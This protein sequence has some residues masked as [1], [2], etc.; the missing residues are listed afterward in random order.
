[1]ENSTEA[2]QKTKNRA[3]IWPNNST[4]DIYPKQMKTL[5]Q[6]GIISY[7][8]SVYSS[9][10]YNY[11]LHTHCFYIYIHT[12]EY[13]SAFKKMNFCHCNMDGTWGHYAKWNKS[14]RKR[15]VLHDVTYMWTLKGGKKQAHGSKEKICCQKQGWG[16]GQNDWR[17]SEVQISNYK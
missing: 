3:T 12:I 10:I 2:P 13:Y 16:G 5:I 17:E 9:I 11:Y 4:L 15:Q 1:M 14:D 7:T 6:K 8:P